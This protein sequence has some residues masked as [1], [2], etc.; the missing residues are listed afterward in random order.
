MVRDIGGIGKRRR[1][2]CC[3]RDM[4]TE[5]LED[6]QCSLVAIEDMQAIVLSKSIPLLWP[7]LG[8]KQATVSMHLVIYH[9]SSDGIN[10]PPL[11]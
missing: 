11:K 6:V 4:D 9:I 8:A 2:I 7:M 3:S 10:L 5:A 1:M